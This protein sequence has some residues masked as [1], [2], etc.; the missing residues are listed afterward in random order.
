MG[1]QGWEHRVAKRRD[2][3]LAF[4]KGSTKTWYQL[5]G[6]DSVPQ[7]YLLSLLAVD[8]DV[9]HAETNV[10]HFQTEEFYVSLLQKGVAGLFTPQGG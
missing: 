4:T 8:T 7:H 6:K 5:A 10:E 2:E 3:P 9:G 1:S